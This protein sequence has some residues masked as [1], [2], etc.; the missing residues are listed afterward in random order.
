MYGSVPNIPKSIN[1]ANIIIPRNI[2]FPAVLLTFSLSPCHR[3][4]DSSAFAP[5]P[6]TILNAIIS[7]C[8]GN[9]N[10]SAFRA[11]SPSDFIFDTNALSTM[12]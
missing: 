1:N 6:V 9:A 5:T 7:I 2:E 8:T 4:L 12:L 11:A 3:D 10:V